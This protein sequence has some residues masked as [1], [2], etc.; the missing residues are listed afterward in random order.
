MTPR[1]DALRLAVVCPEMPSGQNSFFHNL[2]LG[3]RRAG[4]ELEPKGVELDYYPCGN[5]AIQA[6]ILS[7]LARREELDGV[8]VCCLDDS[9][10]GAQFSALHDRGIPIVT[11]NAEARN[12]CRLAHVGPPARDMGALAAE[13][14]CKMR[15]DHRRLLMVGGDKRMA[16]LR[17]NTAGF[18]DYIQTHHPEY[19]L[20]E[21]NNASNRDLAEELGKV[22]TSL[23]DVTG[24]YCSM[25]RNGKLVCETLQRLGLEQR[26]KLVC[27]DVFT[28]LQPYLEDGTVDATIWQDPRSQSYN[29]LLLLYHYLTT[30]RLNEDYFNIRICPV[31]CSNFSYFL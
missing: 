12:S 28:D 10:M 27:T 29:A 18:Y 17:A 9:Q 15:D 21:V 19:S 25:T 11:F 5:G 30:G 14:L 20:L 26:V 4:E 13:L 16:N 23:D 24:V 1:R 8:A 2:H 22:F 31:M 6:D 7:D 3:I